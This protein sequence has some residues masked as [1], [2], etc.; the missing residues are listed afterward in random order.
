MITPGCGTLS[1]TSNNNKYIRY[2]DRN[3]I[4]TV[5]SPLLCKNITN[6]N[7]N[8]NNKLLQ[9]LELNTITKS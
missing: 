9:K 1:D 7:K 2:I 3:K 4:F 6:K 8:N 5:P